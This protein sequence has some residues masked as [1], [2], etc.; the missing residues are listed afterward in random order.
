MAL[1]NLFPGAS[2]GNPRAS[3]IGSVLPILD[4]LTH[5]WWFDDFHKYAAAE[6]TVTETQ[7]GATQA[8][9][10]GHGGLLLLTNTSTDNDVVSLQL[11]TTSFAFASGREAW[12]AFR[13]RGSEATNWEMFLGLSVTD[14]SPIASLPSEAVY[15]YKADDAATWAFGS[16]SGSAALQSVSGIATSV[17]N[18]FQ[19]LQ[20]F[21]DG[22]STIQL[23]VD[24]A[25]VGTISAAFASL[26]P[27]VDLQVT[28]ACQAGAAAA[29]TLAIDYGLV[30]MDRA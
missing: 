1:T 3:D 9:A 26:F 19:T 7:A 8:L 21:Y 17:A 13:V 15:F 20:M 10:T 14:T 11:G 28:I 6:W 29:Q 25:K 5:T 2:L 30:A 12:M 24:G 22:K 23:Y 4:P 16:R 18:T 27:T